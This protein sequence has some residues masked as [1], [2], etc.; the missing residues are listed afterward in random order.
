[1]FEPGSV[2]LFIIVSFC[3]A[4]ILIMKKDAIPPSLRPFMAGTTLVMVLFSFFLL[5]YSLVKG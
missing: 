1:M 5:M 4:W 3:L 2:L